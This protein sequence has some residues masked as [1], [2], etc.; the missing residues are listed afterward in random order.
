[1]KEITLLVC[2]CLSIGCFSQ[3]RKTLDAKSFNAE[4]VQLGKKMNAE[5]ISVKFK[6]EIF[7]D[8]NSSVIIESSSGQIIRGKG[9][10]YKMVNPGMI[11]FQTRNLNVV[12]D[13][14]E[15][16]VI[17][18][19]VDSTLQQVTQLQ[20]IP[21]DALKGYKLEKIVFP[22]YY[23]L[24]A[25]PENASIGIMEFYVHTQS[26]ELYKLNMFYP[27]GNYFS[28]S[29]EDESVESPYL[30]I[31]FEPMKKLKETAN[32]ISLENILEKTA[33]GE[34]LLSPKM[35]GFQLKD[36]RYKSPK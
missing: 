28:E 30:T 18:S 12:V 21:A 14:L 29:M 4:M 34:Y 23:I 22:T 24:R 33:T 32:L 2:L 6:K 17:I 36:S 31:I 9:L 19:N 27:P 20:Q 35:V 11:S 1:M 26:T 25:E 8:I 10:E 13:S 5:L 3:E 7:K 15:R 16:I